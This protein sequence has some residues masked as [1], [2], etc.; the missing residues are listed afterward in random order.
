[1]FYLGAY[2]FNPLYLD[3]ITTGEYFTDA[4]VEELFVSKIFH[5]STI[6]IN[7]ILDAKYEKTDLDQFMKEPS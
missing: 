7:V 4:Y 2:N 6:I 1:M 5:T 3:A